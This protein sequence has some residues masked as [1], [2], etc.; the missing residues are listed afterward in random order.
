MKR[1]LVLASIGLIAGLIVGL[2]YTWWISP[3]K[4]VNTA[5]ASLRADYKTRYIQLVAEAF[6]V[7][8]DIDRAQARLTLL[9][10]AHLNQTITAL[11]Q[12]RA[13][14]ESDPKAARS[15]TALAEALNAEPPV[16][17]VSAV[18]VI[19][20]SVASPTPPEATA[21][22]APSSTPT[23]YLLPT[24]AP[25][26]TPLGEFGFVGKELVCD[27]NLQPPLIQVIMLN[28]DG[29]QIPGVEVV[30]EWDGGFDHF[31]TGLKPELGR[32][33]GDF[34]MT[35]GVEYAVHLAASPSA[36]V[37]ELVI[38]TCPNPGGTPFPGSWLL[39]F[40]QP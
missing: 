26:A 5:P 10:D 36:A 11:A 39:T 32:G 25:T 19:S 37:T 17:A 3:V 38:E 24:H 4:Y 40:R 14:S 31:F 7:E 1:H 12:Q 16:P 34:A 6:A 28:A 20:T 9:E 23:P 29:E 13:A 18:P 22:P 8:G 15:L 30:V 33:Y 27:A 35:E 21:T 2:G